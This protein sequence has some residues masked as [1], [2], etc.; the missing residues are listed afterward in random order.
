MT[1][2]E[3]TA[4]R[5]VAVGNRQQD[6]SS[7]GVRRRPMPLVAVALAAALT[8][9]VIGAA[10]AV[11]A[12]SLTRDHAAEQARWKE[13]VVQLEEAIRRDDRWQLKHPLTD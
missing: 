6:T 12:P 4:P 1:T 9:G 11:A 8:G 5:Q 3:A 7:H 13:Y 10:A 2:I